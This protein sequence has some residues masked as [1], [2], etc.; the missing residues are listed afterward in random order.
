[1][2]KPKPKVRYANFGM[3]SRSHQI[4]SAGDIDDI[5]RDYQQINTLR[6]ASDPAWQAPYDNTRDD[7]NGDS[8]DRKDMRNSRRI[9]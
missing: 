5:M 7:P 4:D 8:M 2:K 6:I 9:E 3:I 1:M